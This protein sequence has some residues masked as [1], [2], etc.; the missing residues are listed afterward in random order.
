MKLSTFVLMI[1]MVAFVFAG[2]G[3]MI[4]DM[5]TN[6]NVDINSSWTEDY[7]YSDGINASA[8]ELKNKFDD[9]TNDEKGWFAKAVEGISAIP[10]V[11]LFVPQ[12]IIESLVNA[13][14]IIS[15]FGDEL[16]V[17]TTI[18]TYAIIG[19]MVIIVFALIGWWHRSQA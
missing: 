11:I 14:K 4:D 5:E 8:S 16:G 15:G 10:T 6:Y 13:I 12:V 9:I 7:D 2:V 19:L 3:L 17:P 18:I 1:L